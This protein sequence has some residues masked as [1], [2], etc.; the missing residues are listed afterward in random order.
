MIQQSG[1]CA[2]IDRPQCGGRAVA[3]DRDP[4]PFKQKVVEQCVGRAGIA[5]DQ[6]TVFDHVSDVGD[7]AE[8]DDERRSH[9]PSVSHKRLMINRNKRRALPAGS[10]IRRAQIRHDGNAERAGQ[11]R[12]VADLHRQPHGRIVK[13]RLSM[14]ADNIDRCFFDHIAPQ[15]LVD[16]SNVTISHNLLGQQNGGWT[17]IPMRES[18]RLLKRMSQDGAICIGIWKITGSTD[19]F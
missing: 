3:I 14:K 19:S 11:R 4:G 7:A 12:A 13:N 18:F 16:C 6:R 5:G 8:I 15:K 10:H 9:K 2:R 1:K 17:L